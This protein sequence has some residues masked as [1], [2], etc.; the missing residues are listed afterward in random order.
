MARLAALGSW[1]PLPGQ[2]RGIEH[3]LAGPVSAEVADGVLIGA[4]LARGFYETDETLAIVMAQVEWRP[5]KAPLEAMFA[6]PSFTKRDGL[7]RIKPP[8]KISAS[9]RTE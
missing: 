3:F 1:G 5:S 9:Q 2:T 8:G 7:A 4:G 6:R